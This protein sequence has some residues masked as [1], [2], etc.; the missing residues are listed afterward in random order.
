MV[1]D[2]TPDF[3]KIIVYD[4]E[5]YIKANILRNTNFVK[6]ACYK[7]DIIIVLHSVANN[8]LKVSLLEL[9][10]YSE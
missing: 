7:N 9:I 5:E 6:S 10:N 3:V 4:D 1:I 8:N 2:N